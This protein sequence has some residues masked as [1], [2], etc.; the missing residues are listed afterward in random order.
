LVSVA[1]VGLTVTPTGSTRL[2]AAVADFVVSATLVARTVTVCDVVTDAG[3]VYKPEVE[4]VP[5]DG[6]IDHVTAVLVEPVTVALN[7]RVCE[8][9]SVADVGLTETATPAAA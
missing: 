2:T 4:M 8:L 1:E 6:L 5:T 9:L 7:C 3:A